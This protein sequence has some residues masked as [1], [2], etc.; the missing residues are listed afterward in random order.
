MLTTS[1]RGS[2]PICETLSTSFT[3]VFV[4]K[5]LTVLKT[6]LFEDT[7]FYDEMQ[8]KIRVEINGPKIRI[9]ASAQQ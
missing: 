7:L 2:I 8:G 6:M 1:F 5:H 9:D 4:S 3:T